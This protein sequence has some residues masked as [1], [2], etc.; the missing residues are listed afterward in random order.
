MVE[1]GAGDLYMERLKLLGF[2]HT[3]APRSLDADKVRFAWKTQQFYSFLDTATLCQ[4][5]WGPAWT[6]YGPQETV[7]FVQAV[8]GW[9]DFTLEE[10]LRIGE[11]RI[12]MLRAF[13]TREGIDRKADALPAKFFV[14]LTGEGPTAG[15]ALEQAE[16]EAAKDEYY[17]LAGWDAASGNPTPA[18][19]QRL[20]LEWV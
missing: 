17:R 3:L 15:V 7:A 11:R 1:E 10:L 14:P 5:V 6:L 12:N 13:N 20:G 9:K 18:T 16:V 2:D 8:T 4:F 19:L